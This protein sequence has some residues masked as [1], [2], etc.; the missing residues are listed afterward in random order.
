MKDKILELVSKGWRIFPVKPG[1]K[2]PATAHGVKDATLSRDKIFNWWETVKFNVGIATGTASGIVVLDVD[3]PAGCDSL[4]LLE[5]EFGTLPET[6]KVHTPS[7]GDH[8]YFK[9]PLEPL[10]NRVR[11]LPGLDFRA[12]GGYVLG[13][14]S[15]NGSGIKYERIG[16]NGPAALPEYILSLVKESR[17]TVTDAAAIDSTGVIAQ[18]YRNDYLFKAGCRLCRSGF[19]QSAVLQALHAENDEKCVP[20][21]SDMEIERIAQSATKYTPEDPITPETSASPIVAAK[22]LVEAMCEY[23]DDKDRVKGQSYYLPHLDS[24]LGGGMREGEVTVWHAEAKV[25]KNTFW[26]KLMH[27]QLEQ[28]QFVGY[29]SRELTPETEVLPNILSIHCQE[30]V[31]LSDNIC[32]ARFLPI[33]ERW[34]LYFALGY[35]FFPLDQLSTWIRDLKNRGVTQFWFD[36]LH[37]MLEDPEDHKAASKLMKEIKALAKTENIHISVI[38]QPNKLMDGQRLSLNSIKGGAAMGQ[39]LD[40]LIILER[41]GRNTV[42]ITLE[43]ARSKLC[44]LGHFYMKY[45]PKTTDLTILD[46]EVATQY[47]DR[48]ALNEEARISLD[49]YNRINGS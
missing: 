42:K 28:G 31:W 32:P 38:I 37:Y 45:N 16:S 36:H 11:M 19:S 21:L 3:G 14:G 7:G 4:K 17:T 30:N 20:P 5:E 49:I 10:K 12:D 25:G 8:Y 26:H 33:L 1:E 39:A 13:A 6:Y 34:P 18:G 9:A 23:L 15:T 46:R 40:N 35:G 29:A 22:D 43:R 48:P 41:S 27:L 47:A 2:L 44:E 24:L